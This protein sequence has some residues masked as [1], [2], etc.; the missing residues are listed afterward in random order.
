MAELNNYVQT[1]Y[2][3][4]NLTEEFLQKFK[5]VVLSGTSL[6]DQIRISEI[7]HKYNIPLIIADVN[8]LFSRVFCDFG[9]NFLVVDTTGEP[10]TTALVANISHDTQGVVTCLDESRHGLEDG[11]FV[12][13][14]EV[15]GMTEINS[16]E[17]VQIKTLGPYTFSIGDTSQFSPY[18]RGGIVTQVKKSKTFNF[19]SYSTS[20]RSPTFLLSDFSKMDYPDQLHIAYLALYKYLEKYKKFPKPWNDDDA[21]KFLDISK[22]TAKEYNFNI[23]LNTELFEVFAKT[24]AGNFSPLNAIIGGIVAQEVMKACSGKFVPIHQWFYFDAIECISSYKSNMNEEQALPQGTRYD[25]LIAIFGKDLQK[26]LADLKYFIVGAGAIGCELLKNFAMLGVGTGDGHIIITDMDLIEKSNLNR[27]FLFRSGDVQKSKALVAAKAIKEM[28]PDINIVAHENRVGPETEKIYNDDF[29]SALD[30]VANALDNID[31]RI[32]MDRK[33]VYY[34]KPLLESGTLGTKGNTQIIVPFLTE[35][36]SS[37]QDP[38]EKSI[39]IC[40]LKNFPNAIEHTLQ[41]ARDDFEGLFKKS[42]ENASLYLRDPQFIERTMKLPGIQPLEIL[43]SVKLALLDER[44]KSFEDCIRWAR[45]H[46]QEQYSNQ[47]QQLLFNFPADQMTST[48][49]P[50]WSG[51]KR[52]PKPLEFDVNNP[53]HLDYVTAA[54]FLKATVY[55]IKSD[56]DREKIAMFVK[57]I[58]VPK[59]TPRSGIKIAE[60]DSQIQVTNGS[61]NVDHERLSQLI[62]QIPKPSDL[63]GKFQFFSFLFMWARPKYYVLE[64]HFLYS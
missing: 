29:F 51:P 50:F 38:P 22:S 16:I 43:E 55:G 63:E 39:P 42:A 35:S 17:P 30:G 3:S 36:Y 28:N 20:V 40:T 53:L 41:W 34:R 5:V 24:S 4:G 1:D 59:F 46:W 60:T 12:T 57:E 54:S 52:C 23:D 13:F 61:G 44:P 9:D 58:E 7:T 18:T 64:S 48:G 11:D 33:C 62:S 37:S 21:S 25:S 47:I 31:A 49:Q 56:Y 15:Q 14:S 27:Q 8:G 2:Y 19:N 45:L 6:A 10:A 32:Y 26:K